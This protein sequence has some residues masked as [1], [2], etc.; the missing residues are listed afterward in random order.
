MR[1]IAFAVLLADCSCRAEFQL[2][3]F[4]FLYGDEYST[5]HSIGTAR[6]AQATVHTHC[7]RRFTRRPVH[8]RVNLTEL[9]LTEI[10]TC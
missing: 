5:D 7:S 8:S 2:D 9:Y 1:V 6:I 4:E 10:C 3:K